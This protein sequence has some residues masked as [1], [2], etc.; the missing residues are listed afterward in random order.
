MDFYLCLTLAWL[1]KGYIIILLQKDDNKLKF[2]SIVSIDNT[3]LVEPIKSKIYNMAD[4]VT[5]YNDYPQS[6]SEIIS[7][8]GDADCVLVSWNTPIDKE[9]IDSC[10]NISYIGMCCSLIDEDSANVDIKAARERGIIV[11][12]VRDYGDEGV[13]EYVI[14]E[15]V[16]LLHGFGQHQWK[17]ENLELTNQKLG[18]IGM[19]TLGKMLAKTALGFG[20]KVFYYN[21]TRKLDVEITGVTYLNLPELLKEVDIL[22]T[23]LPKNTVILGEDQFK[24]FGD[25]K[26]LI[27]TTL[28]PTYDVPAFE[29]WIIKENNYAIFDKV[30]MGKHYATLKEIDKVI[31]TDKVAG[32][33]SQ[34]KERLSYKVLENMEMYF[35]D[36]R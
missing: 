12:G 20:M 18:I 4:K 14:S 30:A 17:E 5:Y 21:R 9:V 23:H 6:N 8:I 25:N 10:P 29:E 13:V 26:I 34:A 2:K 11:L 24:L 19:G 35:D 27:N 36:N 31:Y 28:E 1:G 16:R 32:F 7:R 15:L 33:T 22:S 3:G